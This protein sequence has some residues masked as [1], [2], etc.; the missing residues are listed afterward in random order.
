M[1]RAHSG[2]GPG[3]ATALSPAMRAAIRHQLWGQKHENSNP[4]LVVLHHLNQGK[5]HL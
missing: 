2:M 1:E 5:P 3:R 4:F